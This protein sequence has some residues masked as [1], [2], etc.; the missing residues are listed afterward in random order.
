[1]YVLILFNFKWKTRTIYN[2]D[3]NNKTFLDLEKE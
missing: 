1:M 2:Q 3:Y